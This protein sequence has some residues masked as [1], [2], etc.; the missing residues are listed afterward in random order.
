MIRGIVEREPVPEFDSGA[1]YIYG[2]ALLLS[3]YANLPSIFRRPDDIEGLVRDTYD[4][5]FTPPV[6][7]EEVWEKAREE[8]LFDEDSAHSKSST[9]RLPSPRRRTSY[10]AMFSQLISDEGASGDERGAAQVRDA[11]P[12]VE[13]IPIRRTEYGYQPWG[14]DEEVLDGAELSYSAAFHLASS[15]VRLPVRMTRWESDFDAV[16]DALEDATPEQWRA[17]FLPVSYTH[18]TLPTICSV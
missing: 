9:F 2:T 3:T 15:T 7:W 18:L 5:S 6:G 13:V 8:S 14:L 12:A 1:E 4:R 17:H 11:E 16:V 10:D